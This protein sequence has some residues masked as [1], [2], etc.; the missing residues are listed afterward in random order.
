MTA[1][2]KPYLAGRKQE[3]IIMYKR[4]VRLNPGNGNGKKMIAQ[5]AGHGQH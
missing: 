2:V 5:I 1:T 4:S 3:A